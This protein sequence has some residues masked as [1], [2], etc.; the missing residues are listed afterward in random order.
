M[1]QL[2]IH[3]LHRP[4]LACSSL[5]NKFIVY[6]SCTSL[7]YAGVRSDFT[8]GHCEHVLHLMNIFRHAI[9]T[10]MGM[11]GHL[12]NILGVFVHPLL[13]VGVVYEVFSL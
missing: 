8:I 12:M 4:A 11:L 3:K 9:V 13:C 7:I 5:Y 1:R 10:G 2:V 6:M